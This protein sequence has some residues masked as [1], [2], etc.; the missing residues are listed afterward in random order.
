M[1]ELNCLISLQITVMKNLVVLTSF[2]LFLLSSCKT[3]DGRASYDFEEVSTKESNLAKESESYADSVR[4]WYFTVA[5][6]EERYSFWVNKINLDIQQMQ[7]SELQSEYLLRILTKVEI[8][9]FGDSSIVEANFTQWVENWI[10]NSDSV[11]LSMLQIGQIIFS[12]SPAPLSPSL[13]LSLTDRC[14]CSKK[15]DWC[16]F[17]GGPSTSCTGDCNQPSSRGCGTMWRYEC[18]FDCY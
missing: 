18:D 4:T 16:D 6:A 12:A 9:D 8:E 15:S 1:I 17:F 10:T 5:E 2:I 14:N 7:L 13:G 3:E 11:G